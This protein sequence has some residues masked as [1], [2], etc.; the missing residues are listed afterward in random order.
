MPIKV[1]RALVTAALDGSL[2]NAEFRTDPYFGFAV[3]TSVPGVE[4][5]LLYPAKTWA[6]K[7]EF[8]ETAR[9]LV[10]MFQKNFA[11]YEKHVDADVPRRRPGSADRGGVVGV[12]D[13]ND[14]CDRAAFAAALFRLSVCRAEGR[15]SSPGD[16]RGP[17]PRMTLA[18][19]NRIGWKDSACRFS[20]SAR[21]WSGSAIARAAAL[22]GHDVIVAEAT[23][24]H[25]Q[26]RFLAQQRGDPWRHVLP[27]RLAARRHCMRGRRMLYDFCASHGVPHR[28][29][30]S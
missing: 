27:D 1:T 25:R 21:A 30:A 28:A 4:P 22:A 15:P 12:A 13:R 17:S 16:R 26:R 9:K 24:R 7:K 8:D 5:H 14:R 11:K 18:V 6:D 3:P 2:K 10:G 20:S 23:Q 29:A 19:H